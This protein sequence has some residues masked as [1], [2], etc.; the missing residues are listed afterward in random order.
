MANSGA[1]IVF[2]AAGFAAFSSET[3]NNV[4]DILQKHNVKELD[5]ASLYVCISV[6]CEQWNVANY[7]IF[8]SK[9]V[10]LSWESMEHQKN[11]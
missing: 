2:G 3:V 4:L 10:R 6:L 11:S 5:T 9:A 7:V 8:Y 1:S